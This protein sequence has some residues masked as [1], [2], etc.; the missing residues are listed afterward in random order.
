MQSR[1]VEVK[2]TDKDERCCQ[3]LGEKVTVME[4]EGLPWHYP[5]KKAKLTGLECPPFLVL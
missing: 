4:E 1:G 5:F 2:V 3:R